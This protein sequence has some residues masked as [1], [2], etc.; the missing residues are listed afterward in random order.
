MSY[1][2]RISFIALSIL[3]SQFA[4]SEISAELA[5]ATSPQLT[6]M[7]AIHRRAPTRARIRLLGTSK[8]TYPTKKMPAPARPRNTTRARARK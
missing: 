5:E 8:S 1:I 2:Q 3:F 6:M 7:R 4:H